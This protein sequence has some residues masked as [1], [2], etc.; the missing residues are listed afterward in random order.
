MQVPIAH[1]LAERRRTADVEIERLPL[2]R[3]AALLNT[4]VP[5]QFF[6]DLSRIPL[7][8][9]GLACTNAGTELRGHALR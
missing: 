5:F 3:A 6:D 4:Q 1:A 7:P 9:L 2:G 8:A